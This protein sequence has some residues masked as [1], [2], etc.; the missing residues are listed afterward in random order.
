[1]VNV[2]IWNNEECSDDF[3]INVPKT[4]FKWYFYGLKCWIQQVPCM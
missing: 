4:T 1:M 2:S 3:T